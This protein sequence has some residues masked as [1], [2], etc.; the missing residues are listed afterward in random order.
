[1]PQQPAQ[2]SR[3]HPTIRVDRVVPPQ[4]HDSR[5]H[6]DRLNQPRHHDSARPPPSRAPRAPSRTRPSAEPSPA[7]SRAAP[8][9]STSPR[10]GK[11][12]SAFSPNRSRSKMRRVLAEAREHVERRHPGVGLLPRHAPSTPSVPRPH[13]ARPNLA[14]C[15]DRED[16]QVTDSLRQLRRSVTTLGRSATGRMVDRRRPTRDVRTRIASASGRRRQST[17]AIDDQRQHPK[18]WGN[19][20]V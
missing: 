9:A 14:E 2:L 18:A 10:F 8:R 17:M 12:Y 1:M 4:A 5:R 3:R 6:H 13:S 19:R 11:A 20:G 15:N 7:R 16:D